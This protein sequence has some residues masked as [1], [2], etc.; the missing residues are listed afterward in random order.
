[1][2]DASSLKEVIMKAF[3][4]WRKQVLSQSRQERLTEANR[5]LEQA[6]IQYLEQCVDSPDIVLAVFNFATARR[7]F[8]RNSNGQWAALSDAN[9]LVIRPGDQNNGYS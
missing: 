4:D 1:M 7:R 6:C 8:A 5:V 2:P 3:A 9:I